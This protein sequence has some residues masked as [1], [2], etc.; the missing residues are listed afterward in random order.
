MS[1]QSSIIPTN[2]LAIQAAILMELRA[3][4]LVICQAFNIPDSLAG[5][6]Q[7]MITGDLNNIS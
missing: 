7:S 5:I 2:N 4:R 6:Q 3:L 1:A